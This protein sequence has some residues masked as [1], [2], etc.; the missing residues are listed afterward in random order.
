MKTNNY[1]QLFDS[2]A[3]YTEM[4]GLNRKLQEKQ[5]LNIYYSSSY[6]WQPSYNMPLIQ[7]TFSMNPI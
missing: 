6:W 1:N 3:I 4:S 2:C 7:F 5:K